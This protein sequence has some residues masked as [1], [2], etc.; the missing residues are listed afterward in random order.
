MEPLRDPELIEAVKVLKK[1]R[2]AGGYCR[3][4][5]TPFATATVEAVI[6]AL[7]AALPVPRK[8]PTEEA[9]DKWCVAHDLDA[10]YGPARDLARHRLERLIEAGGFL[11]E[12]ML[13]DE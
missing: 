10:Y 6:E 11:A 8:V 7:I 12:G 4:G 9:I 13:R 5:V 1:W 3:A 2:A